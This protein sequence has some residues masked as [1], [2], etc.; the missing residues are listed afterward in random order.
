MHSCPPCDGR[1]Y[2]TRA[3]GLQDTSVPVP[4]LAW[5]LPKGVLMPT[6]SMASPVHTHRKAGREPPF[7]DTFLKSCVCPLK[8]SS[9][10]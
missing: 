3:P 6:V 10:D 4:P 9:H 2:V 5:M 7:M 8:F 1:A